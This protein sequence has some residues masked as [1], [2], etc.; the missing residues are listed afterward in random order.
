MH[1]RRRYGWAR[2]LSTKHD[3]QLRLTNL[4]FS[5]PKKPFLR[6]AKKMS[7]KSSVP[8]RCL[9]WLSSLA[10][11]ALAVGGAAAQQPGKKPKSE[12]SKPAEAAAAKPAAS[13]EAARS[14]EPDEAPGR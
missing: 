14:D 7:H 12:S 9:L 3:C 10:L 4:I 11:V 8:Q 1:A 2:V 13:D 5:I 6:R